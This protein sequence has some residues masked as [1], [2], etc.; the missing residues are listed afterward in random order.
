VKKILLK[1]LYLALSLVVLSGCSDSSANSN[2]V[3][4]NEMA[5][6]NTNSNDSEKKAILVVSF[7]TSYNETRKA[8]IE[9]IENA[10]TSNFSDFEVRRA[11]TSQTIINKLA[12]RDGMEIDNVQQAMEKI[13]NDGIKTLIVQ[14]THVMNGIEYDEMVS[15]V[16]QFKENFT[17][18]AYGNPLLS[19]D[20]DYKK[21]TE[22][23][24]NST[25]EYNTDKTSIVFMGHGT[26]HNAN[27]T[28]LKLDKNFKDLGYS[29][30][31]VGT[32][33]AT[34]SF[35]DVSNNI[36]NTD[37]QKIILLP[38]MIVAG[39]HATND[40]AGDEE[41]SWKTML[42]KE[43]YEVEC[44]LKGLGE[45][46]EVQQMFVEHTQDAVNSIGR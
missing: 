9:A 20:N 25:S 26:E 14:P 33:E 7:G 10:I 8:T 28:Y 43:G 12:Q 39:D 38:L 36:K 40:M 45:Y 17:S 1:I 37:T 24:I 18:L 30:Y 13:V 41:D 5:N 29:N 2:N 32:V 4:E 22:I 34:P 42:K 11:F 44:I 16:D 23:L 35:D 31:F 15:V 21:L 19:D 27:S 6:T 3:K 46:A